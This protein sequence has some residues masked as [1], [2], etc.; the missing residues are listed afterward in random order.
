MFVLA[1]Y[2]QSQDKRW[3]DRVGRGILSQ[4]KRFLFAI[5][6]EDI[7]FVSAAKY[8]F[9]YMCYYLWAVAIT[10]T[11]ACV[12]TNIALAAWPRLEKETEILLHGDQWVLPNSSRFIWSLI[13]KGMKPGMTL[14]LFHQSIGLQKWPCRRSD[15]GRTAGSGGFRW[16]KIE[17]SASVLLEFHSRFIPPSP[18]NS[19]PA[20]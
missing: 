16:W 7:I 20:S 4:T 17:Q 2:Q 15:F 12:V 1:E 19:S 14:F 13:F 18:K 3:A 10:F 5:T 6:S 11:I 8:W 9:I